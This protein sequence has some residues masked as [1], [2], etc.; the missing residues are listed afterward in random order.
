MLSLANKTKIRKILKKQRNKVSNNV[1]IKKK[2][3]IILILMLLFS[4]ITTVQ[5]YAAGTKETVVVGEVIPSFGKDAYAYELLDRVSAGS[6]YPSMQ[7]L[8]LGGGKAYVLKYGTQLNKTNK[9]NEEMCVLFSG[10]T[11]NLIRRKDGL[12]LGHGNDMTYRK[13]DGKLYVAPM[14][15]KY[16]IRMRTDGTVEAKI[17]TNFMVGSIAC[18]LDYDKAHNKDAFVLKEHKNGKIHVMEIYGTT[19]KEICQFEVD[20]ALNQGICMYDGYLYVTEWDKENGDS[21]IYRIEKKMS[22]IVKE[23]GRNGEVWIYKDKKRKYITRVIAILDK[24]RL[25]KAAGVLGT[26]IKIEIESIAFSDGYLYFTA[27]ANYKDD[28][29]A[30]KQHSLDGLYKIKQQLA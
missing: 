28:T 9:K 2:A 26:A 5:A 18:W 25:L 29:K 3:A 1:F 23:K 14:N 30:K 10:K 12:K 4:F 13:L 27:N 8:A 7:G 17:K 11:T 6:A 15:Q 22:T 24:R 16:I 21:Y 19:S 20:D